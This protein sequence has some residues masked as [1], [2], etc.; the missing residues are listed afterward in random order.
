MSLTQTFAFIIKQQGEV[1]QVLTYN[2]T[3][4]ADIV[5]AKSNI[6][7]KLTGIEDSTFE[8]REFVFTKESADNAGW[9]QIRVGDRITTPTMG[10]NSITEV[11]PQIVFGSLIGYRVRT[12]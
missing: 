9:T 6:N 10:M 2:G 12:G 8:G 11:I 4:H 3:A 5:I 1:C 7:A